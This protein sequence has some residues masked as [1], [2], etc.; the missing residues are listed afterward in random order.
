MTQYFKLRVKVSY[1]VDQGKQRLVSGI[2]RLGLGFGT[3]CLDTLVGRVVS[4]LASRTLCSST[5][6]REPPLME[7]ANVNNNGNT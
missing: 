6:V 2:E 4:K 3:T 5:V 7:V 1:E